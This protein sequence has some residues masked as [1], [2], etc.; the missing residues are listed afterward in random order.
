MTKDTG[1][2][3]KIDELGRIVIPIEIRTKLNIKEKD[4]MEI[5][6]EKGL[7]NLRKYGA[8]CIFCG[9]N[10]NL[11]EYND[12]FICKKCMSKLKDYDM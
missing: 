9:S 6:V 5:Y 11:K 10:K 7:I 4:Q 2:I 8:N 12:K 1:I 3:R